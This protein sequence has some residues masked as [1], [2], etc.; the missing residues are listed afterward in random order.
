MNEERAGRAGKEQGGAGAKLRTKNVYVIGALAIVVLAGILLVKAFL[1]SGKVTSDPPAKLGLEKVFELYQAYSRQKKKPP[2]DE[3]A[4][5]DFLR[6]LPQEEKTIAHIDDN[7]DDFLISPRDGQ[8]FIIRYGLI[9]DV[10]GPTKAVAW[11]QNGKNGKR[12]VALSVGYV[13][14]CDEETFQSYRK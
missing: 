10:G 6:A 12:F 9:V 11:E 13:Q 5:K 1:G 2:A 14:E 7:V 3:Q 4:F 8:K